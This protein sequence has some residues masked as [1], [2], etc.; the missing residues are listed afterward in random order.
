MLWK[1]CHRGTAERIHRKRW[2]VGRTDPEGDTLVSN[3]MVR[4]LLKWIWCQSGEHHCFNLFFK[5]Y[6]VMV[7]LSKMGK[8]PNQKKF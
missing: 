7:W 5:F 8:Y 2:P 4:E 1:H 6:V 3:N